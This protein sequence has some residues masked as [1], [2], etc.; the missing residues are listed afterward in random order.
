MPDFINELA[1]LEG[2]TIDF[3]K[4]IQLNLKDYDN[5]EKLI[6]EEK[7]QFPLLVKT[8]WAA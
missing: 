7:F 3:P 1:K 6:E 4:T 5:A 8:K 2:I